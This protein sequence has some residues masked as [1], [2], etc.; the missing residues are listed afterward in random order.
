MTVNAVPRSTVRPSFRRAPTTVS[1]TAAAVAASAVSPTPPKWTQASSVTWSWAK[2][3]SRLDGT[4][5]AAAAAASA[6]AAE[7]RD[8]HSAG[9]GL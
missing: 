2:K 9:I 8:A 3:P 5:I 6:G 4:R 7:V 1:A